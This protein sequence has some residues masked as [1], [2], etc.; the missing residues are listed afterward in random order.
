MATGSAAGGCLR[1]T[2]SVLQC[3]FSVWLLHMCGKWTVKLG[4]VWLFYACE[5]W[6]QS[7]WSFS[8]QHAFSIWLLYICGKWTVKLVPVWLLF[9]WKVDGKTGPCLYIYIYVWKVDRK[10]GPCLADIYVRREH[11]ENR[12]FLDVIYVASGMVISCLTKLCIVW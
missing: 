8:G 12:L 6:R 10:T 4:P 1:Q 3:A 11:S 7:E 5:T 9:T 2:G